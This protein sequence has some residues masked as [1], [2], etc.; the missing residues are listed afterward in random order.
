MFR[1]RHLF[2]IVATDARMVV[3]IIMITET[4]RRLVM[5]LA[6]LGVAFLLSACYDTKQEFTL[7]PD[8]S[9]K[10]LHECS[11]Q[12]LNLSNNGND[13]S[14]EALQDAIAK[15]I[16]DS[17]GVDA[18]TDVSFKR[19]E[20]DRM[21]FR[22]TAYFKNI[23][24]LEI[25]NQSMLQ[26]AWKKQGDGM[27]DLTLKLKKSENP[28]SK[29]DIA[30]MTPEERAK[31]IKD[32]RA[33]FQQSK[34]MFAAILGTLK[35]SV[36]FK[37]PGKVASQSNF[38]TSAAG[39]LDLTFD[40]AKM[41]DALEKLINDDD[42]WLAKN[43]FDAQD[44]PEIDDELGNLL[45]GEK[46][47]VKATVSSASAPLFDY[48][49][50]VAAALK[51]T[52]ALQKRLG[53]VS[54]APPAKGEALK[55]IQV[56]GVRIVREVDKKLE[57]RP[58]NHYEGYTLSVLAEL[59]GSVVDITDK[60]SITSATASDGTS[61]LKGDSDWE[62]RLGFPQL[63]ADK[64]AV[65]FDVELKLPPPSITSIK[66]ISGTLRYRVAGG[67]KKIDLGVES[68]TVGATGTELGA[69]IEGIKEGWNKDGSQN[70]E[71]KLKLKPD[72]LK[73]ASLIVDGVET[74]LERNGY[75]GSGGFTTFTFASKTAF[76]EKGSI[77]VEIHDQVQ[78]F[79]T[80][81][82]IENLS[83]LGMPPAA[84]K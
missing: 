14:E 58:F 37:L 47:P 59:H 79:D 29:P 3:S 28:K 60:S 68:L 33:K 31:K 45:F 32:D 16:T 54:I 55:S 69:S 25:P 18:W 6:T 39:T 66:E 61:L 42:S 23:D 41:I 34:P 10:V 73:S 13:T 71:I 81:F 2:G 77:I 52:K 51:G 43:G 65:I 49:S 21:W 56:V 15:I 40:G 19:L 70:L 1:N 26:F 9:G 27:A 80:S 62:R 75:S 82:I 67:S 76:P 30:T 57:V 38:K 72:D 8:G 78:T 20:D 63:S 50:E 46:A 5:G 74:G 44:A 7:N 53:A 17:K 35:Q 36:S 83:L 4:I 12:N 84:E 11:F 22:G 64:A 24:E 48:A